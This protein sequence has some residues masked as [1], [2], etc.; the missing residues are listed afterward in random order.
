MIYGGLVRMASW[1]CAHP[2][3]GD[4]QVQNKFLQRNGFLFCRRGGAVIVKPAVFTV[5]CAAPSLRWPFEVASKGSGGRRG[6]I[7]CAFCLVQ[8][9]QKYKSR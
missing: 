8:S 1:A 2:R 6:I 9:G 5:P 4:Q 3:P 7:D